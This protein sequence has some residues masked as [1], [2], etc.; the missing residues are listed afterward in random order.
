MAFQIICISLL[1]IAIL[2]LILV[3]RKNTKK[4]GDNTQEIA[5]QFEAQANLY[6]Q[7]S[8]LMLSA[9]KNYNESVINGINQNQIGRASCR[10]RV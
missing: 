7:I 8:D 3:L 4:S 2:L 1:V 5:R 9:I 6:K 10:E